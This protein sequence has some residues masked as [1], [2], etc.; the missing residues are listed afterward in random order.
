MPP[1]EKSARE[2]L[3][4][5]LERPGKRFLL[6]MAATVIGVLIAAASALLPPLI[7]IGAPLCFIGLFTA[8]S[9]VPH[10]KE[11]FVAGFVVPTAS[12]QHIPCTLIKQ[13]R[14]VSMPV[15]PFVSL[16]FYV[17]YKVQYYLLPDLAAPVMLANTRIRNLLP[18]G[19]LPAEPI[20]RQMAD[21]L[22]QNPGLI[23][24]EILA[25]A[26]ERRA[27]FCRDIRPYQ[28]T[29][30]LE[31]VY[32]TRQLSVCKSDDVY[33]LFHYAGQNGAQSGLI[34]NQET[35]EKIR[36]STA[37]LLPTYLSTDDL[38]E[39]VIELNDAA[40]E[41]L[42]RNAKYSHTEAAQKTVETTNQK[43][44]PLTKKLVED[45]LRGK[46]SSSK[47]TL[48]W[49]ILCLPSLLA[50]ELCIAGFAT[51]LLAMGLV[52]VPIA[53]G[54]IYWGIRLIRTA[55]NNRD[56][57]AAGQYRVVKTRCVSV[58]T[59]TQES[60]DGTYTTYAA[61]LANGEI[62]SHTQPFGRKG[63]IFY[64]LYLDGTKRPVSWF[65]GI[66]YHPAPD[67]TVVEEPLAHTPV[68]P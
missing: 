19:F 23:S 14:Y 62:L 66:N 60:D 39:R 45:S 1:M 65:N 53:G 15:I 41:R 16:F 27:R 2:K 5:L 26:E 12:G 42:L 22:R 7:V 40:L 51:G 55:N 25:Q 63:D 13:K 38:H 31:E 54:L 67:L 56:R 4:D 59:E 17:P 37:F 36:Q 29:G 9:L 44:Q 58:S 35:F 33:L 21:A 47:K 30:I 64:L 28:E 32:F 10:T 61:A 11:Y 34:I 8:L 46:Q 6:G 20:T 57:I 18:L 43:K 50:T 68:A 52:C 3:G 48:G 24:R 49:V